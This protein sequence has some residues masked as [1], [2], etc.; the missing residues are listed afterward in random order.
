MDDFNPDQI[1]SKT[2]A[3]ESFV[4]WVSETIVGN[5][6]VRK[7]LLLNATFLLL[8]NPKWF[9]AGAQTIGFN[10]P[11]QFSGYSVLY[12]GIAAL[13]FFVAVVAAVRQKNR[14]I[15]APVPDRRAIKG[16]RSFE[17]DDGEVFRHLQREVQIHECLQAFASQSFHFGVLSGAS[18]SGKTSFLRAGLQYRLAQLDGYCAV[19]V[20]FSNRDPFDS[21]RLAL[22]QQ[23][24]LRIEPT[25]LSTLKKLFH[26]TTPPGTNLVLMF[27]Q[28]EQFFVHNP[29]RADRQP[30]L[31]LMAEWYEMR[32]EP[33]NVKV[34]VSIRS[35]LSDRLVELQKAMGY[36]LGPQDCFRLENLDPKQA[37]RVFSAIAQVEGLDY[38]ETFLLELAQTLSDPEDGLV[39][40]VDVQVL[41]W[42]VQAQQTGKAGLNRGTYQSFGG[43]EGLLEQFMRRALDARESPIR[44]K[45]A[46]EVLLALTNLDSNTRAG[47]LVRSAIAS[48]IGRQ[49]PEVDEA[50]DWL[51]HSSVRLITRVET[52]GVTA[53]EL[54]HERLIPAIRKVA[55]KTLTEVDRANVLLDRRVNEWLSN[56]RN[57]RY[58]LS[59]SELRLLLRQR[60]HL[61]WGRNR[62]FKEQLIDASRRTQRVWYGSYVGVVVA[63]FAFFAW[64]TS[65]HGL[66][67][68]VENEL[69]SLSPRID[70]RALKAT[71]LALTAAQEFDSAVAAL[72]RIPEGRSAPEELLYLRDE[73]ATTV[74]FELAK[75]GEKRLAEQLLIERSQAGYQSWSN[76]PSML[77]AFPDHSRREEIFRETLMAAVG[78]DTSG[79][80]VLAA[81]ESSARMTGQ[82]NGPYELEGLLVS[83]DRLAVPEMAGRARCL[84]ARALLG[85]EAT[86]QRALALYRSALESASTGLPRECVNAEFGVLSLPPGDERVGLLHDVMR[87]MRGS[88]VHLD[89]A[90]YADFLTEPG[91]PEF[92]P[93]L[94]QNVKASL[95]AGEFTE[96]PLLEFYQDSASYAERFDQLEAASRFAIKAKLRIPALEFVYPAMHFDGL[97]EWLTS[98]ASAIES[99]DEQERSWLL[100][101]L[102]REIVKTVPENLQPAILDSLSP[103]LVRYGLGAM[104]ETHVRALIANLSERDASPEQFISRALC[105]RILSLVEEPAIVSQLS[106]N[107]LVALAEEDT[108]GWDWGMQ[109]AVMNVVTYPIAK[110]QVVEERHRAV[111][112]WTGRL[113]EMSL[114]KA[115]IDARLARTRSSDVRIIVDELYAAGFEEE[116][117]I[118][119]EYAFETAARI[120]ILAVV[121]DSDALV[122]QAER[123]LHGARDYGADASYIVRGLAAAAIVFQGEQDVIRGRWLQRAFDLAEDEWD[124]QKKSRSS[125]IVVQ[126]AAI[127]GDW[128]LAYNATKL[129]VS[130]TSR[131][132]SLAT[133]LIH[134]YE[135]D[136]LL[137]NSI[138]AWGNALTSVSTDSRQL[139]CC[140]PRIAE[141]V[142]EGI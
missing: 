41:C 21:V 136:L 72:A 51:T 32:L 79:S 85:Q 2:E 100:T 76:F 138:G 17:Q 75:H 88:R 6:T 91:A 54:A 131:A 20:A 52:D 43:V 77:V 18:G 63:S 55:N 108:T 110:L 66:I 128:S 113:S 60:R 62:R 125:G 73:V 104:L 83:I 12:G 80:Q 19:H 114:L 38:D 36:S 95:P 8:F 37:S 94:F 47:L 97:H 27:D 28:F 1:R 61:T 81:A 140:V 82:G 71:I 16:L 70:V 22:L 78:D 118:S 98:I 7:L 67:Y 31:D 103:T 44:R 139:K 46:V 96:A 13:L 129:D 26:A 9:P 86:F 48:R 99:A 142:A 127:A 3:W 65:D 24:S 87:I 134:W 74:Y 40:P 58:R 11:S 133:I 29:K 112:M 14:F 102:F 92:I 15:V 49:T 101:E 93:I 30:F 137:N 35:D 89:F 130:E 106:K 90:V 119:L 84:V 105:A 53:Y 39:S 132:E 50:I 117:E 120:G 141:H 115:R 126:A 124:S 121:L 45:A 111:E 107:L 5:N 64:W 10:W 135:R 56:D 23:T 4:E 116:P 122:S 69:E 68:R 33:P 25:G 34:L 42:M 109:K 123:I 57:R 59:G